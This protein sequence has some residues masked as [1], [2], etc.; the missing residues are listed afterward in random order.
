MVD[1]NEKYSFEKGLAEIKRGRFKT[2]R[3]EIMAALGLGPDSTLSYKRYREGTPKLTVSQ[4]EKVAAIF[5]REGV[6]DP[7]GRVPENEYA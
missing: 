5:K 6:E 3:V 1:E 2:V 7:W 4:Y